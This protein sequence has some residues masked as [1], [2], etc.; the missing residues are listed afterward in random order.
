MNP[1][2]LIIVRHGNTFLPGEAP[3]RVGGRTDLPLV[4]S[5]VA[6]AQALGLYLKAIGISPRVI[7]AGPLKRT[8]ETAALIQS[9]GGFGAAIEIEDALRELDYGP[10]ENQIESA[11]EARLGK[12]AL[13]AWEEQAIVPS[14]W[15]VEVNS[16]LDMWEALGERALKD[17][18][19][20]DV[21]VVT[22]NG[23][24]RFAAALVG[25]LTSLSE[26]YGLKL[27]TGAYGVFEAQ[28]AG[29][30]QVQVWNKRP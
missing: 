16:L 24:A 3:R 4:P 9:S 14:G 30:W 11:V 17:Y 13:V 10:D 6:Q 15:Q 28:E 5:G 12:A 2:R 22:S 25:G 27:A 8:R 21:L 23:V 19:G 20:Q 18:A 1:T 29:V 7:F 26:A